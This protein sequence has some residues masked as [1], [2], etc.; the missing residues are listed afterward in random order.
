M[1]PRVHTSAKTLNTRSFLY[2]TYISIELL[3]RYIAPMPSPLS[4]PVLQKDAT[5]L[6]NT[7]RMHIC[8]W[9][10]DRSSSIHNIWEA[11]NLQIQ[12]SEC[13]FPHQDIFWSFSRTDFTCDR[14]TREIAEFPTL[15]R[16]TTLFWFSV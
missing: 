5:D 2:A 15:S 16:H 14:L 6:P 11:P 9:I 13:P 12:L 1:V 7:R 10:R 8:Q 3:S 4:F